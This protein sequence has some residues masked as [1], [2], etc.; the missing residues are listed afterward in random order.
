MHTKPV[1]V[2]AACLLSAGFAVSAQ[3]A[4][5]AC[6]LNDPAKAIHHVVYIEFDNVHLR[7]D[8]PNVPSD[9]EQ[10]PHLLNFLQG[11]GTLQSK[12]HTVLISHT[13]AGVMSALS[14]LYPDRMGLNVS[15][16]FGYFDPNG[17]V[18]FHSSFTYW[19]DPVQQ[20]GGTD[21]SPV[22][23]DANGKNAPAPWVAFTRA[24]CDLGGVALNGL[25]LETTSVD[26]PEVFGANSPQAAEA[27]NNPDLATTDYIGVAVHCAQGSATCKTGVS[28]VLPDQPGGY[29][30][31]N[32]LFG[33]KSVIPALTG[34]D[35]LKDLFGHPVADS[36]GNPGFPGFDI[37]PQAALAYLATFLEKGVPVVYAYMADAHDNHVTDNAFGPG[38]AGYVA[39][40]KRYDAAFEAFF[41]RLAKDGIDASNTLFVVTADEGDHF[42]GG[43]PQPADCNGVTKPC[44][45]NKL[46]EVDA[47]LDRLLATQ[48]GNTT[49]FDIHFDSA[50]VFYVT[51]NPAPTDPA[52]RQLERDAGALTV[53]DV[54][55]GRNVKAAAALADRD[56]LAVLHMITADPF[57]TPSFVMFGNPDFYFLTAGD[58]TSCDTGSPCVNEDRGFAWN[59]GD[60]QPEIA[61][62]FLG[63]VGP[64]ITHTGRDNGTWSDH[65]DIHP[66]VLA[67]LGLKDDY[68]SDGRVLAESFNSASLPFGIA[69]DPEAYVRL[70][71][72]YK[73]LTAPFGAASKASLVYAT[74]A[75]KS[76]PVT[77]GE[78]RTAIATYTKQRDALAARIRALLN[79]AAFSGKVL[80]EP[81]TAELT[82]QAQGLIAYIQTLAT[83]PY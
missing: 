34:S 1:G 41:D 76:D 82:A 79:A 81:A 52:L 18:H 49:P 83:T 74:G 15:N 35:T 39:Q 64:G 30:G 20:A 13:A 10:M 25:S 43:A 67:L 11:Q 8:N 55:S 29:T 27:K 3:A 40:L 7:R 28:D 6:P 5:K 16:S 33:H 78:Y 31:F 61:T 14:G 38:E 32:A 47:Q 58:T 37:L 17:K 57:R 71:Q 54:I 9:L 53:L 50:P 60:I 45:Y 23:L 68:V 22:L 77:Y 56:E 2:L 4:T 51:G 73:Q 12:S 19:T 62:T 48:Q 36:N 42:A 26:I 70:A 59:H 72:A 66:T 46:G 75:I 21:T 65:T 24:G 80:P 44:T 63:L 69:Q